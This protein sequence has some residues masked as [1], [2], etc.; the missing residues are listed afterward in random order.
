[1]TK[2]ILQTSDSWDLLYKFIDE[3]D[4]QDK[5]KLFESFVLKWKSIVNQIN[6][7]GELK[8]N[9]EQIEF[10]SLINEL[11]IPDD[12]IMVNLFESDINGNRG[13]G[14][15]VT[16]LPAEFYNDLFELF[17]TTD[18]NCYSSGESPYWSGTLFGAK[19]KGYESFTVYF[20]DGG[21]EWEMV[22]YDEEGWRVGY[23]KTTKQVMEKKIPDFIAQRKEGENL[24]KIKELFLGDIVVEEYLESRYLRSIIGKENAIR[25]LKE[26]ESNVFIDSFKKFYVTSYCPSSDGV[27]H[28]IR[29]W[30]DKPFDKNKI[31]NIDIY[32]EYKGPVEKK[33]DY[34]KTEVLINSNEVSE[35]LV[36]GGVIFV[37]DWMMIDDK[38]EAFIHQGTVDN[39]H[40]DNILAI[41]NSGKIQQILFISITLPE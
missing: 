40:S 3:N 41:T 35:I 12:S 5:N 34:D 9:E 18:G 20:K 33:Y 16:S 15:G 1:M 14:F 11:H 4:K 23:D 7:C 32:S 22:L 39:N 8:L 10:N 30:G 21:L 27:S 17:V 29:R 25:N 24:L 2:L 19:V 13:Y 37:D 38:I 26:N 31:N 6:E 36:N 28:R